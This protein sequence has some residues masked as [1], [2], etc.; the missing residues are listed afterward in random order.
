MIRDSRLNRAQGSDGSIKNI[1]FDIC[2]IPL[3]LLA[4][5]TCH[6]RK[7]TKGRTNRLFIMMC[8]MSLICAICDIWMEFVVNPLPLTRNQII[9]GT[10]LSFTYK[11]LRNSSLVVYFIH[12]F[13]VTRTEYR[14]NTLGSQLFIWLPIMVA[15]GA[16]LQNFFTHNVFAVTAEGG[17]TRGPV[18]MLLYVVSYIYALAGTG[19]CIYCRRYLVGSKWV[20]LISVYV[21]TFAGVLIQMVKPEYLVE[22][23]STAIGMMFILLLIMR[24]EE[25]MDGQ[26]L[27]RDWNAYQ[28]TLKRSLRSGRHFQIVVVEIM[29]AAEIR[30]YLGDKQFQSCIETIAA[31][32]STLYS[33]LHVHVDQFFEIPGT[34][35]LILDNAEIDVKTLIP[36]FNRTIAERM[37]DYARQGVR[38]DLEYC[39]IKC[40]DDIKDFREIINFGHTFR[41]LRKPA[42]VYEAADLIREH[43]Y[44]PLTNVKEILNRAIT[45]DTLEMYFQPIYDIR[46]GGFRS[47]EALARLNDPV[48]GMVSPALFIPAAERVG[49][50]VALGDRILE[51]VFSFMSQT[52]LGALG[53]TRIE[54]NLSVAQCLQRELPERIREL[55]EKYRIDPSH[56]NFEVTETLF[57]NLGGIMDK[58][59]RTL[60]DMGYTFSLDDYGVGYSNIQ[61]LR[62]L[63]LNIIKIDKSMVDDM[64]T[65]DGEVII[66]NTVRM[67]KGIRKEL[68]VEGVETEQEARACAG[69]SCDYIQGYYYS[70]PLPAAEFVRFLVEHNKGVQPQSR[71]SHTIP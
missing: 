52:D 71:C 44:G 59:L 32:I 15:A 53:I 25:T 6:A 24:P 46:T 7:M 11:L 55:Q 43:N 23:F 38:F 13:S 67:M 33:G 54:I 50:I 18:L 37:E 27:V 12:I 19:Y 39:L 34:F 70:R 62:A 29:N 3:Y 8:C 31:E 48:Y 60:S 2:A 28:D 17:Y 1:F 68:V 30:S 41:Y 58:N 16:L 47:A 26:G 5:W 42:E 22:M 69:L 63:P 49:M 51:A 35:Y 9:L 14:L 57:D 40:P 45:G 4:L 36:P 66:E 20:A 65:S 56:V 10:A 61:R 21:L 64:F